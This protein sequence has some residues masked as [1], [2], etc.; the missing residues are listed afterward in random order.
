[1]ECLVASTGKDATKIKE[2]FFS[3]SSSFAGPLSLS[4]GS[5]CPLARA[6]TYSQAETAVF[7][8]SPKVF[9]ATQLVCR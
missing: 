2:I 5:A 9:V 1:M 6:R 8:Q 7:F 4:M 3:S